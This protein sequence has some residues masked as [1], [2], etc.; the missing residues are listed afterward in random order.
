[1]NYYSTGAIVSPEQELKNLQNILNNENIPDDI[2]M[3]IIIRSAKNIENHLD[4]ETPC[5]DRNI[6]EKDLEKEFHSNKY[7]KEMVEKERATDE[8]RPRK[9]LP[10]NWLKRGK[11]MFLTED[12]RPK[13]SGEI[14]KLQR[15]LNSDSL[16]DYDK[17]QCIERAARNLRNVCYCDEGVCCKTHNKHVIP[18]KNCILR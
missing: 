9:E 12:I 6:G 14:E 18:H 13:P 15:L 11:R 8:R 5:P 3:G 7:I 1:M 17:V 16:S 10:K 4:N 2:K